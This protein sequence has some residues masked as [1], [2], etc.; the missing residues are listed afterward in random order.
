MEETTEI[1]KTEQMPAEKPDEKPKKKK[2]SK[3]KI[4]LFVAAALILVPLG[5]CVYGAL[6]YKPTLNGTAASMGEIRSTV[7]FSANVAGDGREK[8]P[9]SE[10]TEVEKVYFEAGDSVQA[11][12]LIVKFD[13]SSAVDAY[14]KATINY[15][16]ARLQLN[17][18]EKDYWELKEDLDECIEDIEFY[19]EKWKDYED[20]SDPDDVALYNNYFSKWE[21]A[22]TQKETLE[23]QIPSADYIKIQQLNFELTQMNLDEAEETYN[24]LPQDIYAQHDGV[25]ESIGVTDYGTAAKGTVAVS[26]L[27]AESNTVEFNIGRYDIGD[28][29]VGQKATA[30]IGGVEYTGTVTHIDSVA[31]DDSVRAEVTLDNADGVVPGISAELD[32]ETYFNENCLTIPIEASKTDRTGDYCYVARDNG[33]GTYRPEKVYIATGNS[34]LTDVEVLEG[35]NEGD[36]VITNP[37]ANIDSMTS[38]SLILA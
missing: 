19:K 26:I 17:E 8:Y 15:E 1:R 10:T 13:N 6:T 27:T 28:I 14:K 37:P 3:K 20:S 12:D 31:K 32:I 16:T 7:S 18:T 2:L 35:L 22:K 36:I 4:A 38:A 23:K 30:T 11:G 5:S 33:D 24:N 21:A 9:V 29:Q 25:I 34:S